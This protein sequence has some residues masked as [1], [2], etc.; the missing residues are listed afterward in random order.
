MNG[1]PLFNGDAGGGESEIRRFLLEGDRVDAIIA[2][3][4]ELFY[5]TG[6]ATFIWIVTNRKAAEDRGNVRLIDASRRWA[7]MRKSLGSKRRELTDADISH[8]VNLYLGHE[9][10]DTVKDFAPADFG[11]RKIFVERPLRLD[12]DLAESAP[13]RFRNTS[14]L[15]AYFLW[16]AETFGADC[17][18]RLAAIKAEVTAYVEEEEG[19]ALLLADENA[20]KA[21]R[22]AAEKRCRRVLNALLDFDEHVERRTLIKMIRGLR[23]QGP[24]TWMDYNAFVAALTQYAKSQ[25][26]KLTAG[27]LKTIRAWVTATNPEAAP[28]IDKDVTGKHQADPCVGYFR[29]GTRVL[30]FE[31]DSDLSDTERVPLAQSVRDYFQTEVMPHVEDAWINP[32]KRDAQDGKIGVVGYE[33][34]F[35][36]YFYQYV[37]PRPLA[38]ID[39][40]LKRVELEIAAL[41]AEVAE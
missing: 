37:P 2:L 39:A 22:L 41:L 28:V 13:G 31:F 14:A 24:T 11:F 34:N 18:R 23:E 40:D 29:V 26:E 32:D 12:V 19:L 27:R 20:A 5:N 6:I 15:D 7:A 17:H 10:D 25:A 8:I 16:M 4:T 35:N 38:A 30:T 36:R 33:I 3:P 1:S 21:E 9:T